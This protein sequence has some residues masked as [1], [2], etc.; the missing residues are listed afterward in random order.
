MV[1]TFVAVSRVFAASA[2]ILTAGSTGAQQTYPGRPI[3]LITPF[4]P[5][6]SSS[7]IVVR[8]IGQKLTE[9]WGQQVIVDSRPGGNAV[10][11]GDALV[12]S[13]PDGHTVL[14]VTGSHAVN[15]LLITNLPY[16]TVKDFAPVATLAS[17]GYVL[18]LTPSVPA[19]NLN[20]FIA[21]AKS[22]PGQLNYASSGAIQQLVSELFNIIA[23][24]KLQHIPYKGGAQIIPDLMSGQVQI[25]F[26]TP[27]G[28]I[29]Q[30]RSGKLKAIAITGES[31]LHALPQVVTFAEA[32]LPG[33]DAKNW[34]GI[35][36]PAGTP[37]AIVDKLSGELAKFLADSGF[38]EKLTSQGLDPFASSPDQFA[39]LIK[40]DL[41][42]YAR[43]VKAANIRME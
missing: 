3:R 1:Q 17:T 28:A 36:A 20:E 19:N 37:K 22:K 14:L 7:T 31:R 23:G 41:E 5:G 18:V 2:L 13:P 4:P 27:S 9:S 42:K 29:P 15:P 25:Y 24:V 11:A 39:A 35:L 6:S 12:K 30:I 16:D 8:L 32:G 26:G 43:I 10:I 38:R 33:Y 21:L 34:F 40:A